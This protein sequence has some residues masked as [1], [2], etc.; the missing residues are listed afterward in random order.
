MEFSIEDVDYFEQDAILVIGTERHFF[1]WN[2]L[3]HP[4]LGDAL[5]FLFMEGK[6]DVG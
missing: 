1:Q 4:T 3:N 2:G 5:T 6:I